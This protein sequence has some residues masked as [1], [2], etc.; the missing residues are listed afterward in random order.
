VEFSSR[1]LYI[2]LYFV[3][4]RNYKTSAIC[5][6]YF[7]SL[8]VIVLHPTVQKEE[9]GY[10]SVRATALRSS[11][12][13][14]VC[15]CNGHPSSELCCGHCNSRQKFASPIHLYDTILRRKHRNNWQCC[16]GILWSY[17]YNKW[18]QECNRRQPSPYSPP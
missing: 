7:N 9:L 17:L 12:P 4:Q 8:H 1:G 5:T 3:N 11:P 14:A 10:P 2:T 13:S 16:R 18:K 6:C 15:I